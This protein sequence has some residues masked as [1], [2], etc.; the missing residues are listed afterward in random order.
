MLVILGIYIH[1]YANQEELDRYWEFAASVVRVLKSL[2]D[3]FS[4][5]LRKQVR[6]SQ[7]V[8]MYVYMFLSIHGCCK[9]TCIRCGCIPVQTRR[10]YV[11]CWHCSVQIP[12][13]C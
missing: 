9:S 4:N 8:C 1:R 12:V 5:I 3:I 10:H 11:S 6:S 13:I 7:S 2:G